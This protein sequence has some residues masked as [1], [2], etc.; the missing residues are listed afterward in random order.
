MKRSFFKYF[1]VLI[2]SFYFVE[3]KAQVCTGTLGD[4]IFVIDFGQNI[5]NFGPPIAETNYT[6]VA[7]NPEDGQYTIVHTTAG[8]NSGWHQNIVDHNPD[9]KIGYIMVVNASI[10]KGIFY[11]TTVN[12]LC[13]NTTYEFSSYII[14][15][16]RN[17]G[18]KPNVKFTIENNG[19]PI[20][21]F[22]TGDIPEGTDKDWIKYGTIFTTPSNFGVITLKMTNENPGGSGNDLAL[23]DITFRACGPT[24]NSS[25]NNAGLSANLCVGGS[26]TFNLITNVSAGY[27]DPVYQWQSLEGSTWT[28]IPG[29]TSTQTSISFSNAVVGNYQYRLNVAERANI[30]SLKCRISSMPLT[31]NVNDKPNPTASN[32]GTGCVG[33]DIKLLV[34]QGVSFSWSGPNGFTSSLQNPTLT[35]VNAS[36]A[37]TYSVTVFN[38]S[39]CSNTAQTQVQV[40]APV[41]ASTNITTATICENESVDLLAIGGISYSWLPINGLSNAN[42]ANPK[43]TPKQ[44]TTYT[45]TVSNGSCTTSK[46]VTI[47]VLKIASANAGV[48]KKLLFGQAVALNGTADGDNVSYLWSPSAYLDDPTKLNPIASPPT[49]ITYTLTVQ[50]NCNTSTDEVFIKVYPKIEI[51]TAFTPNGDGINDTW[52]IP[53]IAAFEHPRLKVVNRMGQLVYQGDN[54][55]AWNGKHNG[56]NLPTGVYYYTLYLNEDFKI[57]SGWV[58]LTR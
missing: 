48:D 32:S 51:P 34:D 57:Y 6:Y 1:F 16:L 15:I 23:D 54:T 46:E 18:I 49:D 28:D 8:L 3:I 30:N 25:I 55:N 50:S 21:E 40:V 27:T 43:A 35:N 13:P 53:S 36:S 9:K 20:K 22:S 7:G 47:T 24:I 39:G 12:G 19:I 58:L 42:I 38:A 4:P 11:Q 29:E 5:P 41:I 2:L 45:V 26:G 17:S 14:N 33:S 52:E 56:K 37:G 44:T 10:N 31:I